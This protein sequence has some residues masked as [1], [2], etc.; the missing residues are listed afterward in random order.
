MCTGITHFVFGVIA[1][2]TVSGFN[3]SVSSTSI[4]TGI[5][6]TLSTASSSLQK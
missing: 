3:V 2:R 6:P 1:L 5:A 4:S